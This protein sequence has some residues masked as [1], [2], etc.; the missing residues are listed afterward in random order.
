VHDDAQ[1]HDES[2]GNEGS[3]DIGDHGHNGA[4]TAG[5]NPDA[6]APAG[7]PKRPTLNSSVRRRRTDRAFYI[8]LAGAIR[9]NERALERLKR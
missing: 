4:G 8:R 7:S 9:Q 5:L 2:G 6:G 1:R 3:T